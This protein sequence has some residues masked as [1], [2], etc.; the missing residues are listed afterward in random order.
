M[1]I[2]GIFKMARGHTS[3]HSPMYNPPSTTK[4]ITSYYGDIALNPRY[5]VENFLTIIPRRDTLTG[6]LMWFNRCVRCEHFALYPSD[7]RHIRQ[8]HRKYYF[9]HES[10]LQVLLS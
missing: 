8:S 10:W 2:N 3:I 6:K 4:H 7:Y 5:V 1:S 9:S